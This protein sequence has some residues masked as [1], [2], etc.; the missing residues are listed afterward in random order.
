MTLV[1]LFIASAIVLSSLAAHALPSNSVTERPGFGRGPGYGPGP[2][3]G[4]QPGY[5][6]GRGGWTEQKSALIQRRVVN[7]ELALRQLI[8]L[9]PNFEGYVVE[10]VMVEVLGGDPRGQMNLMIN[11]Y[12]EDVSVAPRGFVNLFPRRGLELGRDINTLR[13]RVHG[14]M[15]IRSITVNL[16]QGRGGGGHG[17]GGVRPPDVREIVVPVNVYQ[18]LYGGARIDV[19]QYIN[20]AQYR[21]MRIQAIDVE[22]SARFQGTALDVFING[23]IQNTLSI[24]PYQQIH[25]IFP[26]GNAVIGYGADSIVLGAR[27]ELQIQRVFL[28][29]MR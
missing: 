11:G 13:L 20:L 8:G 21:G 23:Y 24:S 26:T 12:S 7:E 14:W 1:R 9:G 2:G 17:G 28:R 25:T 4:P 15:D 27:G 29:L 10:S 18:S 19:A 5:G 22:A 6:P 3:P 16:R